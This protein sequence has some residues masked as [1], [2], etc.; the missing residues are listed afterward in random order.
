MSHT[1]DRKDAHAQAVIDQL[2]A[3][4]TRD[5]ESLPAD[6]LAS[7]DDLEDIKSRMRS[8]VARASVKGYG[9]LIGPVYDLDSTMKLLKVTSRAAISKQVKHH[10]LLRLTIE[11]SESIFPVFQFEGR[12]VRGDIQQVLRAFGDADSFAV[13]Q[14]F[15][16]PLDGVTPLDLL[17]Q[18]C[19]DTVLTE[20]RALAAG[21]QTV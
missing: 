4:F 15:N 3:E 9:D 12:A 5:L 7:I 18:G 16:T 20:A 19:L 11:N 8:L 14:W 13:A 2:V 17:D 1:I 21:W 6:F 10:K